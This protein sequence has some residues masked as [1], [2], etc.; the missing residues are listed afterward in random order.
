MSGLE[1]PPPSKS[2]ILAFASLVLDRLLIFYF[3]LFR[4]PMKLSREWGLNPV[5]ILSNGVGLLSRSCMVVLVWVGRRKT[6]G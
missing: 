5:R 4:P 2:R 1:I 3:H 6:C